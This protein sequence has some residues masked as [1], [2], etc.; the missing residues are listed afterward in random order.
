MADCFG[1][2]RIIGKYI[3]GGSEEVPPETLYRRRRSDAQ[4]QPAYC[5]SHTVDK[6]E[7]EQARYQEQQ[8]TVLVPLR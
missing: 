4:F 2:A 5:H 6:T 3:E 1:S 7:S 8:F